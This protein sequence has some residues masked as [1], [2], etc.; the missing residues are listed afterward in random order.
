MSH[1]I[2]M[3]TT[4]KE[5]NLLEE[6]RAAYQRLGR[7]ERQQVKSVLRTLAKRLNDTPILESERKYHWVH[8]NT[9]DEKVKPD[10]HR[11]VSRRAG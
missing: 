5:A 4:P 2:R 11:V 3:S 1:G 8:I 10:T 6:L 7:K 9:Y